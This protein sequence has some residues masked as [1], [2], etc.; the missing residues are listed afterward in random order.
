MAIFNSFL[1]VYQR[2]LASTSREL[3]LITAWSFLNPG[4]PLIHPAISVGF[5]M[6]FSMK[7]S[8]QLL[9]YPWVS[10]F[11]QMCPGLQVLR[12]VIICS[13][14]KGAQWCPSGNPSFF[15]GALELE[16]RK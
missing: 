5:S 2:I 12:F 7:Q 8:I 9:G 11:V 15:K 14:I 6:G 13:W 16:L 3:Y 4:T 1:Y 10:P